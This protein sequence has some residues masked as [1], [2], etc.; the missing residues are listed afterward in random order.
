M[1]DSIEKIYLPTSS[2]IKNRLLKGAFQNVATKQ[3]NQQSV[4][5]P[6]FGQLLS[7]FA[8]LAGDEQVK[9]A[10]TNYDPDQTE[11][12]ILVFTETRVLVADLGGD[13]DVPAVQAV[14]RSTLA[15]MKVRTEEETGDRNKLSHDWPGVITIE[16]TYPG[17]PEPLK[18]SANGRTRDITQPSELV[19]LVDSLAAD[20]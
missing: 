14:G 8:L 6:W 20:L 5:Q 15:N 1:A 9:Y 13:S 16:L 19:G 11:L 17:L 10:Y 4:N 2:E 12:E 7:S 18:I 3:V